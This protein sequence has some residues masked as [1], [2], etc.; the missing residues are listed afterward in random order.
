MPVAFRVAPRD[1][2]GRNATGIP[3]L[4]TRLSDFAAKPQSRTAHS[5]GKEFGRTIGEHRETGGRIDNPQQQHPACP[6]RSPVEPKYAVRVA[7]AGRQLAQAPHIR[8]AERAG[9]EQ[10]Q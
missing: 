10:A 3:G 9:L 7:G 8:P 2:L 1:S 6:R 5:V 4:G